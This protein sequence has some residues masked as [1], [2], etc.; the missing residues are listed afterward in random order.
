MF[1]FFV[2]LRALTVG[3]QSSS[4]SRL[5]KLLADENRS[6]EASFAIWL[7]K[8]TQGAH[9]ISSLVAIP[10]V[11]TGNLFFAIAIDGL[12]FLVGGYSALLLPDVDTE[13]KRNIQPSNILR[14]IATLIKLHKIVFLQDQLLALAVSGTILLMVKLSGG[15]SQ[16]VIYFNLL[17]GSCIWLSSAF[18]H[19]LALRSRT[20][21]YWLVML[22]GFLLLTVSYQSDWRFVA[23]LLAYMGYWILYHKYTVEIQTKTPKELIGATMAARGLAVAVTLS[24]GELLGGYVN[25]LFDLKVELGIR[26]AICCLVVVGLLLARL[27]KE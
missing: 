25:R 19:N 12:S 3:V 13:E 10:L 1:L 11:A 4:R 14:S 20:V 24:V 21:V 9:V 15:N 2:G 17:F 18:A 7:N 6:R 27:K 26:A 23:Y 22:V 5:I 16:Y 8:V